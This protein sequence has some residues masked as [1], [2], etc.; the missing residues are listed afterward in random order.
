MGMDEVWNECGKV[1]RQVT[2]I[3]RRKSSRER[4]NG[5]SYEGGSWI[6]KMSS[7]MAEY[8]SGERLLRRCFVWGLV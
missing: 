3:L 1:A 5:S 7:R 8:S 6:G 4:G 2:A